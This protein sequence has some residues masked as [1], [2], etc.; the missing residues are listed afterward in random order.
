MF[1]GFMVRCSK[2]GHEFFKRYNKDDECPKCGNR[3]FEIIQKSRI[4]G[5]YIDR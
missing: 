5:R 4:K 3:T 1:K 2:C